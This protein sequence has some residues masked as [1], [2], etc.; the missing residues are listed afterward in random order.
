MQKH[1]YLTKKKKKKRK[2]HSL[3]VRQGHIKHVCK[4]SGS[5]LSKTVWTLGTEWIGSDKLEPAFIVM[6]IVTAV[7]SY[8][9]VQP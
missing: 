4:N 5:Y 2:P 1:K 6:A 9:L 7:Q 8:E 3:T